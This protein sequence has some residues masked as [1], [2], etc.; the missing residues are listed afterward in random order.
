[1]EKVKTPARIIEYGKKDITTDIAPFVLS[2][3]YTDKVHGES[4]EIEIQL[5]D[6]GHLWK[7][8]WYPTKGDDITLHIGYE[9]ESLLPCGSFEIDELEA[10]GPP[11]TVTIRGI[12]TN[13]KKAVREVNT[14]AF[15]DKSLRQIVEDVAGKH[16][17][18]V[19]GN[20][21]NVQV[22]RITQNKEKDLAFLKRLAE[23]YGHVF[24]ITSG[25]LVFYQLQELDA[26]GTIINLDRT[27]FLEWSFKD[28]TGDTYKSAESMYFDP[29]KK[30]NIKHTETASGI[31]TGDTLK[32]NERCENKAQAIARTQAALYRA[33]GLKTEGSVTVQ[34]NPKLAAGSNIQITGMYV[35]DGKYNITSAK[36]TQTRADAYKT[37][38]EIKRV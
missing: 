3:T 16:G 25:K 4:D 24:K 27:N 13:L 32:I 20:I 5:E 36:H 38:I 33:N 14:K 31:V 18:Q 35:Y 1:M 8:N 28:K 9:N 21:K 17:Y 26:A 12:A 29:V 34:G 11:D 23:E 15:E 2:V 10:A 6:R 19:V 22:K 7:S 37:T 30:E